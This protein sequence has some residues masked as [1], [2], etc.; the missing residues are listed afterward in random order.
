[1]IFTNTNVK[2]DATGTSKYNALFFLSPNTTDAIVTS[3]KAI[4][5]II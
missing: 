4:T 3:P 5:Q 2:M 1:M